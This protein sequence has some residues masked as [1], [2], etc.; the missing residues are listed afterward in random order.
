MLNPYDY[1]IKCESDN[2]KTRVIY[3][4]T[5]NNLVVASNEEG[6]ANI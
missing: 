4:P 2:N 3:E 5:L 1:A 6:G